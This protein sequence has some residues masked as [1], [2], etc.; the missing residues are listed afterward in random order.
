[1]NV[2]VVVHSFPPSFVFLVLTFFFL[3]DRKALELAAQ[4]ESDD[5][6]IIDEKVL[7]LTDDEGAPWTFIM[8]IVS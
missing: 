5:D 4:D 3:S 2:R 1:M 7:N 8:L 6:D